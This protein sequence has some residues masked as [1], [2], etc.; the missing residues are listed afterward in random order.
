MGY[1][2][3]DIDISS[4]PSLSNLGTFLNLNINTTGLPFMIPAFLWVMNSTI[5]YLGIRLVRGI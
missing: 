1:E 3:H 5:I 4:K 2:N